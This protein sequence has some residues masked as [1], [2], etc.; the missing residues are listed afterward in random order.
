MK[1]RYM[2]QGFE[3]TGELE[4]YAGGK[5]A[6]LN[7]KVPRRFRAKAACEVAFTQTTRKAVKVNT[8]SIVFKL[9][10]AEFTAKETTRHM[11][12]ALDIAA[13]QIEQQLKDYAGSHRRW[14]FRKVS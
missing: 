14:P 9:P 4:K 10:D 8:C 12:A 13:V 7:R 2:A 11:H 1:I 5:L 3:L 6:R